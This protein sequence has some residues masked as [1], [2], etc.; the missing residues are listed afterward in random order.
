VSTDRLPATRGC[1]KCQQEK[2]LPDDF[3][4][5]D[6]RLPGDRVSDYMTECKGCSKDGSL[7]R[8]RRAK[9]QRMSGEALA[10]KI[11]STAALLDMLRAEAARRP[12]LL[13][14]IQAQ[15]KGTAYVFIRTQPGVWTVGFYDPHGR[16]RPEG[17]HD[18]PDKAA[19]RV[20]YLNGGGHAPKAEDV[21]H[22]RP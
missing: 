15:E 14:L 2:R 12:A 22:P 5:R 8:S 7:D 18:S 4:L 16:W 17:D 13:R 10:K 21:P 20:A 11:R 1:I 19:A 9:V 3:Y 6:K